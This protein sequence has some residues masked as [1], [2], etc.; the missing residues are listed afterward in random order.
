M[1]SLWNPQRGSHRDLEISHRTRDFHIPT[2]D[3]SSLKQMQ[4]T[5]A[6]TQSHVSTMYPVHF[7][8]DVSGC[9]GENA[10]PSV[11]PRPALPAPPAFLPISDAHRHLSEANLHD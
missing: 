9:A 8:T 5:Q 4:R 6:R 7:V 3:R 11:P 10:E 2:A 1:P